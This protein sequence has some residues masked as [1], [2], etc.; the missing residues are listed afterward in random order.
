MVYLFFPANVSYI[1]TPI[2]NGMVDIK[3]A[4]YKGLCEIVLNSPP[5]RKTIKGN[6]QYAPIS[7]IMYNKNT[8]MSLNNCFISLV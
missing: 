8:A 6:R 3:N 4:A 1:H 2:Q 7:I 5:K